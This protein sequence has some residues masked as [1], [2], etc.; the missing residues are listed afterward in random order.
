MAQAEA[1][2]ASGRLGGA[3]LTLVGRHQGAEGEDREAEA[4][5]QQ[6]D[7][8]DDRE[9]GDAFGEVGGVERGGERGG[10]DPHV[11]QAV[12]D[13]LAGL[14]VDGGELL[15][16]GRLAV[17][18]DEAAHLGVGLAVGGFERVLAD[19]GGEGLGLAAGVD[20]LAGDGGVLG[21]DDHLA[22]E[23]G[24]DTIAS[25][26]AHVDGADPEGDQHDAGGDPAV[27]EE[28]AHPPHSFGCGG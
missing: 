25:V 11:A 8:H 24:A 22:G 9:G 17:L 14:F 28:L 26:D 12:L 3:P 20:L 16:A 2:A 19:D 4:G 23:V 10:V 13:G 21:A 5:E 15:V 18:A 6:G 1:T 7:A 27:L